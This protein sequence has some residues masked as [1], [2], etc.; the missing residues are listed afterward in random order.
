MVTGVVEAPLPLVRDV[1][2]DLERFGRWFPQLREWRVLER[3]G[4]VTRV[5][6]RQTFPWPVK[7]RDYVV[8]YRWSDT[9]DGG[10]SLEATGVA[11]AGPPAPEGVV[12]LEALRSLWTLSADGG[13][14][15]ASYLYEGPSSGRLADWLSARGAR[16]RTHAVIDGLAQEVAR[17]AV[18]KTP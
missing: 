1:L 13:R 15:H 3:L 2:L 8:L 14:T 16:S 6:G 7:D 18:G 11:D 10:F 12:R 9:A 4:V 17:R 5:Y